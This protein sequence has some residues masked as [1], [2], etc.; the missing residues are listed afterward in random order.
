[1]QLTYAIEHTAAVAGTLADTDLAHRI[2]G[3]RNNM[4]T[5]LP[6]GRATAFDTGT[7]VTER[8][9]KLPTAATD[10]IMG[11][12]AYSADKAP[13]PIDTTGTDGVRSGDMFNELTR[14]AINV[15]TEQDVDPT[16]D[17][18]VRFAPGTGVGANASNT[19]LSGVF[20]KDYD[21]LTAYANDAAR[22]VGDRIT[23]DTGKVYE[24]ITAGNS[25]AASATGPSGTG[26]DI[27]DGT[28]HWKYV[29]AT[30]KAATYDSAVQMKGARWASKTSA[31][32]VAVLEL[33]LP[34]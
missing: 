34:A 6:F 30:V 14:G 15:Y 28:A 17:V 32:G 25:A 27:T 21:R 31:G 26:S 18:Y 22:V 3:A 8:A 10:T 11:V 33:N 2:M 16:C 19:D 24:C 1:M 9:R 12:S 23:N 4:A 13:G 20:R 7:G 29:G 5:D